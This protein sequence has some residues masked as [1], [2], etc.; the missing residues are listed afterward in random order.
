[1]GNAI[2]PQCFR[3]KG[4]PHYFLALAIILGCSVF[5]EL[6]LITL[7]TYYVFMNKKRG[8]MVASGEFIDDVDFAHTFE[9]IAD[10]VSPA[11]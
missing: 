4:A 8:A 1:M 10:N 7:L 6:V 5:L 11:V 9:D 3:D 2:G